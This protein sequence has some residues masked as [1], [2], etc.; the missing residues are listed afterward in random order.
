MI[1][2]IVFFVLIITTLFGYSQSKKELLVKVE[3]LEQQKSYLEK[4]K[5]SLHK[6]NNQLEKKISILE[7]DYKALKSKFSSL[8]L[9]WKKH[10][11]DSINLIE[12]KNEYLV[13]SL[14]IDSVKK[15][16][17]SKIELM[18]I[19]I[20]S[21]NGGLKL[22]EEIKKRNPKLDRKEINGK[23][24][25]YFY[26]IDFLNCRAYLILYTYG[27]EIEILSLSFFSSCSSVYSWDIYE[28]LIEKYGEDYTFSGETSVP[29]Q[30]TK[31]FNE[32]NSKDQPYLS[33]DEKSNMFWKGNKRGLKF[34]I[35]KERKYSQGTSM[36]LFYYNYKVIN[37]KAKDEKEKAK[38]DM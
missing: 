21:E 11:T 22:L 20:D 35:D 9:K 37:Q 32:I 19:A 18:G 27:N 12:T 3:N 1:R 6:L 38:R 5:D 23:S 33:E 14:Y 8:D 34:T 36:T 13:D 16:L 31:K 7:K 25:K 30:K 28:P 29:S 26:H 10:V 17:D 15:F 4:E 24:K 2:S